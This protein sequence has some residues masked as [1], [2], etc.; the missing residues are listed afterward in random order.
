MRIKRFS[1][2][3]R[4]ISDATTMISPVVAAYSPTRPPR[5]SWAAEFARFEMA[6]ETGNSAESTKAAQ[7][8]LAED[9]FKNG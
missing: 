8:R 7:E 1:D 6:R 4:R 3:T 9:P 2:T 5:R